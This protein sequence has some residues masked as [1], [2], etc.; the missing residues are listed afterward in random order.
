MRVCASPELKECGAVYLQG[1]RSVKILFRQILK[2]KIIK[3]KSSVIALTL[4]AGTGFGM[5]ASAG[6]FDQLAAVANSALPAYGRDY[7]MN[8][9]PDLSEEL[10]ASGIRELIEIG[11]ARVVASLTKEGAYVE[12]LRMSS[13]LRK[14]KKLAAKLDRQKQFEQFEL[15][16]NQAAVA[17]APMLHDLLVTAIADLEISEPRKVL[18]AHDT[19]A[20][21]YFYAQVAGILQRQL[22][23]I[24]KDLLKQSGA[25]DSG[26]RIGALIKF[27]DLLERLMV[28]HVVE[29]NMKGYFVQLELQ[30]QE[31]RRNPDSRSTRLLREVFG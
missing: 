19:A 21:N 25:A 12:S 4:T 24:A 8:Y 5:P 18:A 10:L 20:T 6:V 27:D 22:Q 2:V 14:A 31:I 30:E 15:Q 3:I 26:E 28:E 7:L 16:L 9:R 29:R 13:G 1:S 11:S 17:M 23:P